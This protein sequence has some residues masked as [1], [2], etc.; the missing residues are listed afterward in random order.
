MVSCKHRY[1]SSIPNSDREKNCHK[2]PRLL[3]IEY[4]DCP[5]VSNGKISIFHQNWRGPYFLKIMLGTKSLYLYWKTMG[6]GLCFNEFSIFFFSE[7]LT[8]EN[9]NFYSKHW[10][11]KVHHSMLI[12]RIHSMILR[13]ERPRASNNFWKYIG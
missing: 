12:F 3:P 5:R 2:Q 11:S 1:F 7:K 10:N 6:P 13:M 9:K 8:V 4:T